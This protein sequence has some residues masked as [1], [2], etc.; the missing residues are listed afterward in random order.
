MTP[1]PQFAL[2]SRQA[3]EQLD[4]SSRVPRIPETKLGLRSGG[5][6]TAIGLLVTGALVLGAA[7]SAHAAPTGGSAY[8]F[9]F[10]HEPLNLRGIAMRNEERGMRNEEL[11]MR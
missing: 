3:H 4:L 9:D 10:R 6:R 1:N 5:M 7:A 11:L 2:S 8:F